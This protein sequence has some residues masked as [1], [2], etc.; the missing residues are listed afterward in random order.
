MDKSLIFHPEEPE[1]RF[2]YRVFWLNIP[3]PLPPTPHTQL[4]IQVACHPFS[5]T[6]NLCPIGLECIEIELWTNEGVKLFKLTYIP[7]PVGY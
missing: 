6:F 5:T 3:D 2:W 1:E 7:A 4:S